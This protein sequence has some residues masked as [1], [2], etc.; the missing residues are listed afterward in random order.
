MVLGEV[1]WPT[2]GQSVYPIYSSP[3]LTGPRWSHDPSQWHR[4]QDGV[5]VNGERVV[6]GCE[7]IFLALKPS[8]YS[9]SFSPKRFSSIPHNQGNQY[10]PF[11]NPK[12]FLHSVQFT[13]LKCT[14]Q[15]CLVYSLELRDYYHIT[16][17]TF[18]LSPKETLAVTPH[19]S[20]ISRGL[21]NNQG[22]VC[23]EGFA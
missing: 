10:F 7:F 4:N 19:F 8:S 13:H 2:P 17:R 20:P 18:F 1:I 15:W 23:L 14:I 21:G 11:N 6:R 9:S 16:F 5:R 12:A 22:A 3:M